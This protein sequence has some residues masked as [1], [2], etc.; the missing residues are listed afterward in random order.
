VSASSGRPAPA[1]PPAVS[2]RWRRLA[3][4]LLA[5]LIPV[6]AFGSLE[7][8]LRIAHYGGDLH[9]F[10]RLSLLGGRYYEVN[11]RFAARY[12]ADVRLLPTP[13]NDLLL[14]RKPANGF[15]IFVLGAST[16]NGFPYGYNGTFSRVL[17]DAV[18]DV[19]PRDS[20]EVVNL[21]IAAVNS[22]VLYD[23]VD[24]ILAQHP[25]AVMI[26]AGQ[27]EYYGTLGVASTVRAVGSP[28]LIRTYLKLQRLKLFLLARDLAV[29]IARALSGGAARD[30]AADLME[31]MVRDRAIPLDGP[32][33]R[34]GVAQFR[35]N[36]GAIL[37]RFRD[38][39][40]P[41]FV[42]SLTSN[43]RDQPPFQPIRTG[44][45]PAADSVYRDAQR[46]LGKGDT[47]QA[48][49]LFLFAKDLDGL[50]F[51]APSEF[52]RVIREA[53]QANGAHYVPIDEAFAAA[54]PGGI[55]GKELF[56][57]QL[58]P[59]QEGDLLM[60]RAFFEA[61][62][63]AGF[64]G[65][66]AD[67]TRLRSWQAY[68]DRM[69]LTEFDRRYAWHTI[70]ALRSRWPFVARVD[71]AGY[72]HNYQPTD[73][74]DSAAFAAVDYGAGWPQTKTALADLYRR[75]GQIQLAL[76]EY[77]GLIREQP[78]N[79]RF[80]GIA[81]ELYMQVG[82][83][84]RARD[85]LQQSLGV[86]PSGL[87]SYLLGSLELGTKRYDLAVIHLQQALQFSPDNP[88]VL[89][90]LSRAL[91]MV[92]DSQRARYFMDRLLA[93]QPAYPGLSEW[94]AKLERKVRAP[95]SSRLR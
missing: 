50:R 88:P 73:L 85:M 37:R 74:A 49:R 3:F 58:H 63:G 7:G 4:L 33:Y 67:T 17:G 34:R 11:K 16:T 68:Y 28:G 59:T 80:L 69:G 9:L 39:G 25:D 22:Y 92:G 44:P 71:P 83:T 5:L 15:R 78:I 57:E 90:D 91:A 8:I 18:N 56:W 53:A 76:A 40:V 26:Y 87:T 82:D 66:A 65:R 93:V 10:R 42:G 54:S 46:A 77:R 24:E 41:V 2:S 72:P 31:Y 30:T 20:V 84:A 23:Q 94:R 51:R 89:F 95:T 64:L 38:A 52:N 81:A 45:L 43:L 55:P 13:P 21:G 48:R 32:L 36:L 35:D 70:E 12:F 79:V 6:L 47:A 61:L 27:N 14:V 86:E 29:R 75:R 62:R 19:L 1:S 60:G